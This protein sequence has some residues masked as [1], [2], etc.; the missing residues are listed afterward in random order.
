MDSTLEVSSSAR[1]MSVQHIVICCVC[2]AI[3]NQTPWHTL[4]RLPFFRLRLRDF[5]AECGI[6]SAMDP[7]CR[8]YRSEIMPLPP[9]IVQ[10]LHTEGAAQALDSGHPELQA[11]QQGVSDEGFHM[12]QPLTAIQQSDV[13]EDCSRS[14]P[15]HEALWRIGHRDDYEKENRLQTGGQRTRRDVYDF[16]TGVFGDCSEADHADGGFDR[17]LL[18]LL[19]PSE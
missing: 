10:R 17:E 5:R 8:S 6:R 1:V 15:Q 7:E 9:A 11:Q 13:L 19:T 4:W 2:L 18:N 14:S 16:G 3:R 12:D